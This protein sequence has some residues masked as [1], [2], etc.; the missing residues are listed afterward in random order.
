MNQ[1]E[2]ILGP[3]ISPNIKYEHVAYSKTTAFSITS[4]KIGSFRYPTTIH[5]SL[6]FT[7]KIL[8]IQL[9]KKISDNITITLNIKNTVKSS[10]KFVFSTAT[11][12]ARTSTTTVYNLIDIPA[13]VWVNIC[14]DLEYIVNTYWPGNQYGSLHN[15]EITAPCLIRYVFAIPNLLS[16]SQNGKDLPSSVAFNALDSV[17]IAIA[18]EQAIERSTPTQRVSRIPVRRRTPQTASAARRQVAE[19]TKPPKF[20][21]D[22]DS[23]DSSDDADVFGENPQKSSSLQKFDVQNENDELELVYIDSLDCYYCPANQQF[24]QIDE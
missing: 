13:N 21:T 5:D 6:N 20:E 4:A 3:N 23:S 19:D 17:T 9:F 22:L 18:D 8:V 14:F 24:Y 1:I 11:R 12:A 16:P 2:K 7:N 10:N 15:F